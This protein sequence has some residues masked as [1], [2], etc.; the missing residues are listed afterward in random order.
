VQERGAAMLDYLAE[1]PLADAKRFHRERYRP[2]NAALVVVGDVSAEQIVRI[3]EQELGAWEPAAI[4][5][6]PVQDDRLAQPRTVLDIPGDVSNG[7]ELTWPM[8]AWG[9][10]GHVQLETLESALGGRAGLL[11]TLGGEQG[12]TWGVHVGESRDFNVIAIP[13]PGQSSEE[14]ERVTM[15]SLR[16]VAD[17]RIGDASWTEVLAEAE[18]D[19]L[20][21]A[22]GP[23]SL[24]SAIA[25]SYLSRKDW[26]TTAKQLASAPT[27]AEVVAAA[28]L[29]LARDLVVT[30]PGATS[31]V[32]PELPTLPTLPMR[33]GPQARSPFVAEVVEAPT[34]E[35]EPR[36]LVA[37]SSYEETRHGAGRV[38]TTQVE[39]PLFWLTWIYPVGNAEDRWACDAT[40]ARRRSL[41]LSA[42]RV[43]IY[44][45][46][47]DIRVSVMGAA[48]RFDA[49]MPRLIA[50]LRADT[51][52]LDAD[53]YAT[54]VEHGRRMN[55]ETS[56]FRAMAAEATALFGPHAM[57][58]ALPSGAE[59]RSEGARALPVALAA[60]QR[61]DPDVLYVGPDPD[62][63]REVLPFARDRGSPGP[64]LLVSRDDA[65]PQ[66]FLL[67]DPSL[68]EIVVRAS[69][70]WIAESAR[71]Q[72]AAQIH[73]AL[74]AEGERDS[75]H[76]PDDDHFGYDMPWSPAH[77]VA[78]G[79]GFRVAPTQAV[80]GLKAALA[81]LQ[82]RPSADEYARLHRE[83]EASFRADR[84]KPQRI[85]ELVHQWGADTADPR[86]GQWMALPSLAYAQ[87][88]EYFDRIAAM[89]PALVVTGDLSHIDRAALAELGT[90]VELDADAIMLDTGQAFRRDASALMNE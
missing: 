48:S 54:W 20:G 65:R 47:A 52:E 14:I 9:S 28:K 60:M 12:T 42:A 34:Q 16:A 11:S 67:H 74:V 22:R 45:T 73:V 75:E 19:R 43:E 81:V 63:L 2:N 49:I 77:P 21:W 25:S 71:E 30:R 79:A 62:A 89:P 40:R 87:V 24:A 90:L 15:E 41:E 46:R 83:L 13:K 33:D 39:S 84:T 57:D 61:L 66:V 70:P 53:R 78:I 32:R 58:A 17:D 4:P 56:F 37:G 44:C 86:I 7:I 35:L 18:F 26:A 88:I 64:T 6:T 55:R 59:L 1:V 68:P 38:I 69:V 10:P 72:L 85:P 3:A 23:S 29:L 50:W 31:F 8:P 82:R 80:D 76:H 5:P 51:M 27:R 36:F